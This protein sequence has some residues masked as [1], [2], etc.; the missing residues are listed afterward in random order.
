MKGL[1]RWSHNFYMHED[2]QTKV[3]GLLSEL[4]AK[5]IQQE[6]NTDPLITITR[7][8]VS[9]DYKNATI[10]FTTIPEDKQGTALIYLMRCAGDL[11]RYVRKHMR[12][13]VIPHLEFQIDFGE[14]HRQDTDIIFS[15]MEAA[16]KLSE[17]DEGGEAE[18]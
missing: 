11:R 6:A 4:A 3:A 7:A 13:K 8:D 14:R 1:T 16:K 15:E 5:Y 2:R 9:K 17:N 10:F 18:L 12:I